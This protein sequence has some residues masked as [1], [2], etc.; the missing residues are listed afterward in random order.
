M[1]DSRQ[2]LTIGIDAGNYK[3]KAAF[4]NDKITKIITESNDFLTLREECE[5]FF[6]DFVTSCV[7][8]LPQDYSKKQK[9]EILFKAKTSGFE[10]I[11]LIDS[12]E[13]VI[14]GIDSDVCVLVFDIGKIRS[15]MLL[16]NNNE[17]KERIIFNL[18]GNFFDR[19]FSEYLSVRFSTEIIDEK[20]LNEAEILKIALTDSEFTEYRGIKIYR[21]DFERLIRFHVRKIMHTFRRLELENKIQKIIFTGKTCKIPLILDTATK[22]LKKK[23]EYIEN[24]IAKGTAKK[25]AL[26]FKNENVKNDADFR[27]R[28]LRHDLI[29]VEEILTRSQKDRLYKLFSSAESGNPGIIKMLEDLMYELKTLRI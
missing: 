19:I 16:I 21:E 8:S 1:Q 5:I 2:K 12:S 11:D 27:L 4:L 26:L 7:M 28:N 23:P 20:L 29:S 15:E 22:M 9:D 24:L 6:D 14:L 25:A 13:A 18:S 17:V 3:L 10:N